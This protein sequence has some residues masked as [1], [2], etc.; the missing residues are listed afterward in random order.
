MTRPPKINSHTKLA[1]TFGAFLCAL[2]AAVFS[3]VF[4]TANSSDQ[5]SNQSQ[6]ETTDSEPFFYKSIGQ[7]KPVNQI[8][9]TQLGRRYTLE[10]KVAKTKVEAEKI[11]DMLGKMGLKAYYTPLNR[12]G[13][14]VYRVRSGI[15]KNKK[16]AEK[17]SIELRS[18]KQLANRVIQL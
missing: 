9:Q 17:A 16:L 7:T 10:V 12:G 5:S 13:T 18:K 8:K 14:I 11:I 2:C 6:A 3:L 4:Y 15:Y 1:L